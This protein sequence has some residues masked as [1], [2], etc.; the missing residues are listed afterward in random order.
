MEDGQDSGFMYLSSNSSLDVYPNNNP[1][2]YIIELGEYETLKGGDWVLCAHEAFIPAPDM[3]HYSAL[4]KRERAAKKKKKKEEKEEQAGS[5]QNDAPHQP[6]QE[7]QRHRRDVEMEDSVAHSV[8]QF[9]RLMEGEIEFLPHGVYLEEGVTYPYNESVRYYFK[10]Y[11]KYLL[12]ILPALPS[13]DFGLMD[14][15]FADT[16]RAAFYTIASGI[17]EGDAIGEKLAIKLWFN[18][19]N[20]GGHP[21]RHQLSKTFL[22]M[23]IPADLYDLTENVVDLMWKQLYTGQRSSLPAQFKF[24]LL[25]PL[26]HSYTAAQLKRVYRLIREGAIPEPPP[27]YFPLPSEPGPSIAELIPGAAR[28]TMWDNPIFNEGEKAG[29]VQYLFDRFIN[30][31]HPSL[32]PN[33]P[34]DRIEFREYTREQ[35][36]IVLQ[37]LASGSLQSVPNGFP[38]YKI[39]TGFFKHHQLLRLFREQPDAEDPYTDISNPDTIDSLYLAHWRGLIASYPPN[40]D[41]TKISRQLIYLTDTVERVWGEYLREVRAKLPPHFPIDLVPQSRQYSEPEL[42]RLHAANTSGELLYVPNFI[43][44]KDWLREFRGDIEAE[45]AKVESEV[46]RLKAVNRIL[47]TNLDQC[48]DEVRDLDAS[49][50]TLE[51]HNTLVNNLKRERTLLETKLKQ[52]E[53]E[54]DDLI[55]DNVYEEQETKR[56]VGNE[57]EAIDILKEEHRVAI[58]SKQGELNALQ[59]LF[60]EQKLKNDEQTT[61]L[62]KH[63]RSMATSHTT[64]KNIRGEKTNLIAAIGVVQK[65][66]SDSEKE[67]LDKS[68]EITR[69]Q[70]AHTKDDAAIEKC[71]ADLQDAGDKNKDLAVKLRM[72][73]NKLKKVEKKLDEKEAE[74]TIAVKERDRLTEFVNLSGDA[75]AAYKAKLV[76]MEGELS[77]F[78]TEKSTIIDQMLKDID[79]LVLAR[80][81]EFRTALTEADRKVDAL[82]QALQSIVTELSVEAGKLETKTDKICSERVSKEKE[83]IKSSISDAILRILG[84]SAQAKDEIRKQRRR[85][86]SYKSRL[87]SNT[88]CFTSKSAE[89]EWEKGKL[90]LDHLVEM[91]R[92]LKAIMKLQLGRAPPASP[93]TTT[94]PASESGDALEECPAPPPPPPCPPAPSCAP[95]LGGIVAG[96]AGFVAG[97]V[98]GTASTV[99]GRAEDTISGTVTGSSGGS[100]VKSGGI[101]N[102]SF[103]VDPD[104]L[105]AKPGDLSVRLP[106]KRVGDLTPDR[107]I[108]LK[109]FR[110]TL[111]E[112][113][114]DIADELI[115]QMLRQLEPG[116][117]QQQPMETEVESAAGAV[118]EDGEPLS[119]RQRHDD[120]MS[121]DAPAADTS[122]SSGTQHGGALTSAAA[123]TASSG[124]GSTFAPLIY[125][126]CDLVQNQIVGD[127]HLPVLRAFTVSK[128]SIESGSDL[129][130]VPLPEPQW[131][132]VRLNHFKSVHIYFLDHQLNPLKLVP[133]H[134]LVAVQL[135][136]V[137]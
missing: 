46:E 19:V 130:Y 59:V 54:R 101:D 35:Q 80:E 33:F 40:Y 11:R 133:G 72:A 98:G 73:R 115:E 3:K 4:V 67:I 34:V 136:L 121:N 50:I 8:R 128:K 56:R 55:D 7:Q 87:L 111:K 60:N 114:P 41:T 26:Q 135:K 49:T 78:I 44:S 36:Y 48:Q 83:I 23:K 63:K 47:E 37:R 90:V 116:D 104:D 86:Y 102:P 118:S 79:R 76:K 13:F 18:A 24:F 28:P 2:D 21:Q 27:E 131:K 122:I 97:V 62:E 16:Q 30:G 52:A 99:T 5:E 45:Y 82:K 65:Q 22:R 70:Q 137:G 42:D 109:K 74:L 92:Q 81:E 120:D 89:S 106:P 134:S 75:M 88:V 57:G 127:T 105:P 10:S 77:A 124:N 123:T 126:C 69:L 91:D 108:D 58:E 100:G 95:G 9:R 93:K 71:K 1:Q 117:E 15:L 119:K 64:L 43:V 25:N 17:I 6:S 53:D 39:N 125:M 61:L 31:Q 14:R 129:I 94:P 110:A 84:E 85:M 32:P 38:L 96:T 112:C 12:E 51:Q 66:L 68:N 107:S 20:S 113:I 103:E 132:P 29:S